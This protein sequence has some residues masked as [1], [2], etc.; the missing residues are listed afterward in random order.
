MDNESAFQVD[1]CHQVHKALLH[2]D[3]GYV[4]RPHLIDSFHVQAPEQVG[5]D[6]VAFSKSRCVFS[7]VDWPDIHQAAPLNPLAI[8][9]VSG[10]T[11]VVRHSADTSKWA[12]IH[13]LVNDLHEFKI[14]R[15]FAQRLVVKP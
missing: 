11:R 7:R 13:H 6:F 5:V 4:G 14:Q 1:D 10:A 2:W 12:I 9:T 15:G 3:P 8:H